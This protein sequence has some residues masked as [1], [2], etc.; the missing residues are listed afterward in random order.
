[1]TRSPYPRSLAQQLCVQERV[2]CLLGGNSL[3]AIG[4]DKMV[5]RWTQC[6]PSS[7][8][9]SAPLAWS[10]FGTFSIPLFGTADIAAPLPQEGHSQGQDFSNNSSSESSPRE[11]SG[12]GFLTTPPKA[13][14]ESKVHC[15][16]GSGITWYFLCTF[17]FL[18]DIYS[19][20][21]SSNLL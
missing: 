13:S 7:G 1:M 5:V 4:H 15:Y 19:K 3:G 16:C 17:I 8:V 20:M 9:P 18:V 21:I 6:S 12:V 11:S 10:I 14:R 2:E